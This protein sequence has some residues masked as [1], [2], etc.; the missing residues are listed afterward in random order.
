MKAMI[1][2]GAIGLLTAFCALPVTAANLNTATGCSAPQ[3]V[4]N[5]PQGQPHC[6]G[7]SGQCLVK[8]CHFSSVVLHPGVT[9]R[10][11]SQHTS[12]QIVSR[13][14]IN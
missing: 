13:N 10:P 9:P 11:G 14:C 8:Y 5:N 3:W 7:G 6:C 12:M 1:A 2:L 4:P